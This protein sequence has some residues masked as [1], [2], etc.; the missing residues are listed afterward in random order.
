MKKHRILVVDDEKLVCWSLSEMLT[1]AGFQVETALTGADARSLFE[2]FQPEMVLLD[3]RLPD[4]NGIELL[5]EFKAQDEDIVVVMITAYADADS[6]VNALK[7]GADDYIGKPFDLDNIKH[8]VK[9]SFEKKQLRNEVDHFRRELRKKYDYDNL[10]GNSPQIIDVFK[11]IKVCAQTDA[12]IVLVLGESGTGKQLVARAIHYHSARTD[13]PFIETNCAAIPENLLENELFGHE[14]GAFTDASRK[15]KGMFES[16]AGGSVFLDE[17]GDMPLAMQ[18]KILKIIDSNKFRRLGGEKDLD[19]DVRL[20]TATNQNLQKM[21]QEKKFRGDLYFRLNV[22][23]IQIP[24]LRDRK[25]DIPSLVNYFVERLNEEYGRGVEG[26]TPE[27]LDCLSSYDWPGNVRELRN[28]VERAMMLEEGMMLSPRFFKQQIASH[29]NGIQTAAQPG[30]GQET[31]IG[32]RYITLPPDGISLEDVE[33]QL[34]HQ[35]MER[36]DGNQTQAAKCLHMSRDT[37]RYRIKK[38]SL[39]D[40]GK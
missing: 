14:K 25:E 36:Y 13:A 24:P 5:S 1:E 38:F 21:V 8:V 29:G 11:M 28:A 33:K 6:A 10:I 40:V 23:T 39:Q 15:H 12:K 35:A 37:L 32:G 17:I 7:I 2:S 18:A 30:V 9:Q 22:M 4:A 16:A 31:G 3:V 26:I 20:I 19:T 34:I 27:A